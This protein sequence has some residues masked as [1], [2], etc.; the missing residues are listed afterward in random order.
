LSQKKRKE[1]EKKRIRRKHGDFEKRIF[2]RNQIKEKLIVNF[3]L[4][5]P[6]NT[7]PWLISA[8][9]DH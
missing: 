2:K 6:T 8:S 4:I 5:D 9:K 7:L 3:L 1:N